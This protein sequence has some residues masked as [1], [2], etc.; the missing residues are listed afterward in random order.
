MKAKK[1]K[2]VKAVVTAEELLREKGLTKDEWNNMLKEEIERVANDESLT[3]EQKQNR[4]GQL[5]SMM[6][7]ERDGEFRFVFEQVLVGGGK[8][9]SD[10]AGGAGEGA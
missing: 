6:I 9:V 4:I 8:D 10:Y 7:V 5:W 3:E 2:P 1:I